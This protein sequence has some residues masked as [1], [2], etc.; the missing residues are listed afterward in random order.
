MS[1]VKVPQFV[2]DV[3]AFWSIPPKGW[4]PCI[5]ALVRPGTTDVRYV[6]FSRRPRKRLACHMREHTK[7]RGLSRWIDDTIHFHGQVEMRV[8]EIAR[9]EFYG[10]QE[11]RW[12]AFYRRVGETFNL[13][14]GGPGVRWENRDRKGPIMR[15]RRK[16][17]ES[18]I[19]NASHHLRWKAEDKQIV[20]DVD[21]KGEPVATPL[22][23][24]SP[25]NPN[26]KHSG[27]A[28]GATAP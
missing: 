14:A 11:A 10:E 19:K 15:K 7:N 22:S 3:E 24:L 21:A 16:K 6:G 20:Y 23:R 8:L 4:Y 27:A 28:L 12:I 18:W 13:E 17:A 26:P 25:E 1:Y 5:Y 9:W 2:T